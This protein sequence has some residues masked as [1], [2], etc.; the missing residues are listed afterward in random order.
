MVIPN[1][2]DVI[3]YSNDINNS[4]YLSDKSENLYLIIN[5]YLQKPNL[6]EYTNN[7]CI[8]NDFIDNDFTIKDLEEKDIKII[9]YDY[10]ENILD[11]DKFLIENYKKYNYLYFTCKNNLINCDNLND[12]SNNDNNF[13]INI[14]SIIENPFKI[15]NYSS[16]NQNI[17][18]DIKCQDKKDFPI[19]ITKSF[20]KKNNIKYSFL[21][22][23]IIITNPSTFKNYPDLDIIPAHYIIV[24]TE[25]FTT[26]FVYDSNNNFNYFCNVFNKS[27]S[28]IYISDSSKNNIYLNDD[29]NLYIMVLPNNSLN[30]KFFN[31]I[32]YIIEEEFENNIETSKIL[33][34]ES[35]MENFNSDMSFNYIESFKKELNDFHELDLKNVYKNYDACLLTEYLETDSLTY[36]V[37]NFNFWKIINSSCKNT[38]DFISNIFSNIHDSNFQESNEIFIDDKNDILISLLMFFKNF[39]CDSISNTYNLNDLDIESIS[40]YRYDKDTKKNHNFLS[41]NQIL[42]IFYLNDTVCDDPTPYDTIFS[43]EYNNNNTG[44]LTIHTN[45]KS[46]ILKT[47]SSQFKYVLLYKINYM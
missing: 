6:N 7:N 21:D 35:K 33:L 5:V 32:D 30:S 46:S 14:P 24:N 39:I 38:E 44:N 17:F 22:S 31:K 40:I 47:N 26:S 19:F 23:F 3:A 43:R 16:V 27:P 45:K 2:Y 29:K 1:K 18:K 11:T 4:L 8:D 13:D 36:D 34:L 12:I 28:L 20:D 42:S 15:Y 41:E 25:N 9:N 37:N 10:N